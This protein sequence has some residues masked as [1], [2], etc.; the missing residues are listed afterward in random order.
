MEILRKYFTQAMA[1]P[2][3]PKLL[4]TIVI[5]YVL[6]FMCRC[7]RENLRAIT[8]STFQIKVDPADGKKYI[9][10]AIDKTDKNHS[11]HDTSKSNDGRIY[12]DPGQ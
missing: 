2:P 5:F 10:Q 4:Q 6:Y 12:E 1:G 11:Y 3:N 7:G 8:K 9:F